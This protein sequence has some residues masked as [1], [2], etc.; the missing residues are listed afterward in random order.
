MQ[1]ALALQLL[2]GE[3]KEGDHIL[4]DAT[5]TGE[6]VFERTEEPQPAAA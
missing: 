1:D 4:V 3:F 2:Q 5:P 6:L